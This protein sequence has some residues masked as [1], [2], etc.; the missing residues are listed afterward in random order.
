MVW[1]HPSWI[2]LHG[3]Q[4]DVLLFVGGV[5]REDAHHD[6]V[7]EEE[8]LGKANTLIIIIIILDGIISTNI[9][10]CVSV[11]FMRLSVFLICKNIFLFHLSFLNFE[12]YFNIFPLTCFTYDT[13]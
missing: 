6:E 12:S 3:H 5:Q 4:E 1:I 10:F 8:E 7:R 11:T 2:L 13:L 9:C